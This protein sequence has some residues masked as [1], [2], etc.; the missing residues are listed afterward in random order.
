MK[1]IVLNTIYLIFTANLFAQLDSVEYKTPDY[2]G[3][4]KIV[5]EPGFEFYYPTLMERMKQFDA[6]LTIEEYRFLYYGFIFQPEFPKS[7]WAS[8]FQE[9]ERELTKY[10]QR[11]SIPR[12]NY[13]TVI[14]LINQI[15]DIDPFYIR[16][17]NFLAYILHLKGEEEAAAKRSMQLW[18]IV[19]A[20]LSSGDGQ[21]PETGFHVIDIGHEYVVMN[22]LQIPIGNRATTR[23]INRN[24]CD[25]FIIN[26]NRSNQICFIVPYEIINTVRE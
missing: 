12:R 24:A 20:I 2:A 8:R 21:N 1:K 22:L 26:Q 25:C 9:Q 19:H 18:N 11:R 23:L 15:L 4:K 14:E 10:Y 16:G 6:T 3:I 13:D 5:S 17:I 7:P